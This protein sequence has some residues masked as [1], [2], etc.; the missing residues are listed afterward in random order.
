M[1]FQRDFN[2]NIHWGM[3]AIYLLW[4][5]SIYRPF[6]SGDRVSATSRSYSKHYVVHSANWFTVVLIHPYADD[7]RNPKYKTITQM[8][9]WELKHNPKTFE[10]S[11]H[12][13]LP[14]LK[15]RN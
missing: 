10:F 11:L 1:K 8:Y 3:T 5:F 9:Y 15:H 6:K 14:I 7:Y 13:L 2:N 12:K 4:Y